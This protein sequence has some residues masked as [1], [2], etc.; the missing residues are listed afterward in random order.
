MDRASACEQSRFR[1]LC[2]FVRALGPAGPL[3]LLATCL[4]AI[5]GA[6]ALSLV[7]VVVPWLHR[8]G[9]P[10]LLLFVIGFAVL[11]GLAL[12]PTWAN[13]MIGGW[14][15]KFAAGFPAVMVG[16]AGAA[17]IAYLLAHR[18]AGHRVEELI[19]EHPKWQIVRDALIG[20]NTVRTIWVII[21]LRLSPLLP[22]ETTNVL[23][24]ACGVK[25][26]PFLIGTLIGVM[27]RTAALVLA[28]ASAEKLNLHQ[29][30]GWEW[31][32]AGAV[33]TLIGAAIIALIGKHALDRAT[34]IKPRPGASDGRNERL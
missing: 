25:P 4:P 2:R 13:S 11:G 30:A 34:R 22:F 8:S 15:Y 20:R 9:A 7:R 24:A 14:T 5:G 18:V 33:L 10:G 21:L 12:V 16:L 23:L 6:V 28:A 3:A 31:L 19:H 26:L 29:A 17:M 27:P 32:A 1:R